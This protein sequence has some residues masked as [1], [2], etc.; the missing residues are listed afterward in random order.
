VIRGQIIHIDRFGNCISNIAI[1]DLGPTAPSAVRAGEHSFE[2]LRTT[3]G[4]V[5]PGQSLSLISSSG[6]VEFAVR[7]GHGA[8]TL[9]LQ[10]GDPVE[11]HL[12]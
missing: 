4:D 12:A 5:E 2:T 1:T 6:H 3:Y 9:H 7:D 11:I 10:I 8:R